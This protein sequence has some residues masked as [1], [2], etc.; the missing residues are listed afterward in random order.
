MYGY[1][2]P[3]RLIQ[4]DKPGQKKAIDKFLADKY[5]QENIIVVKGGNVVRYNPIT[6]EAYIVDLTNYPH[7]L[8]VG[9]S[10]TDLYSKLG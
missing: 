7:D 3:S 2:E 5:P 10:A 8:N 9:D 4:I 1:P 6:K